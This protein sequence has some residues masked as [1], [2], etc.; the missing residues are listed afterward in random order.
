MPSKQLV[1]AL[2][3][4]LLAAAFS[5]TPAR[6]GFIM[7]LKP[8]G[9][10]V[11]ASGS[12]RFNLKGLELAS[13]AVLSGGLVDPF[14]AA[15]DSG[16]NDAPMGYGYEAIAGLTGPKTYGSGYRTTSNSGAGDFVGI[17]PGSLSENL[18]VPQKYASGDALSTTAT[19]DNASFASLGITPGTYTWTW[20]SGPNQRFTLKAVNSVHPVPEP[21]VLGIFAIGLAGMGLA[22]GRRKRQRRN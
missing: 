3:S 10:N 20:G 15:A 19:F 22:L 6:A 8:M 11:V 21:P 12:G 5:A 17:N 9:H 14:D 16:P 2:G 4:A 1:A 18:V 7:T 13:T